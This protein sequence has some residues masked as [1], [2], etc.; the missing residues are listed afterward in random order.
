MSLLPVLLDVFDDDFFCD[1]LI[2]EPRRH[3]STLKFKPLE[4]WRHPKQAPLTKEGFKV[5]L[6]VK[7][8]KASE[9]SVKTVDNV[10]VVECKHQEKEDGDFGVVSRHFIRKYNLPKDYD[11]TRVTSSLSAD[12]ILTV[13]A[14]PP[15]RKLDA[16]EEIIN[17]KHSTEHLDL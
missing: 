12:G 10:V 17:E 11:V 16:E 2:L 6:D 15:P 3:R 9:V 5:T 14:P 4:P 1:P 8:F 13:K 7:E